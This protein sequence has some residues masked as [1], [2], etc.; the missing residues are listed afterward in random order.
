MARA[1]HTQTTGS[2]P[3]LC[4][5]H[6]LA[7]QPLVIQHSR[8]A[9]F[10]HPAAPQLWSTLTR[11]S[12]LT[13]QAERDNPHDHDAVAVYWRGAKL[14]YL[15]RTE[16]LVASRLLS[17]RRNLSARIRRLDPSAEYDR[18]LALDILMH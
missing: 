11:G 8:L 2:N 12:R 3:N 14:G 4:L 5:H 16:N 13:L 17:R 18:R 9:G 10:R 1:R 6:D 15:P 7:S